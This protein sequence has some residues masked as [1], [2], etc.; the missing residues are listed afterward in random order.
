MKLADFSQAKFLYDGE[1]S[2]NAVNHVRYRAPELLFGALK[3]SKAIDLWA[4]GCVI[5]EM[6]KLT[7]A[8]NGNT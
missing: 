3:Y 1:E 4:V 7:A 2:I 8:F 5:Y 6:L